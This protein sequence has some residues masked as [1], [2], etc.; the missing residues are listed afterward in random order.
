MSEPSSHSSS[1]PTSSSAPLVPAPPPVRPTWS[2]A[3]E[4]GSV[5]AIT[6]TVFLVTVLGR[7]P[8]RLVARGVAFYYWA[9]SPSTR[10]H[11]ADFLRRVHGRA[12][13]TAEI[14]RQFLRYAQT[15][16]DAFFF[17]AG[18]TAPFRL[19]SHGNEHLT[20]LRDEKRGAILLG[21][22]LGSF[23]AMRARGAERTLPLYAVVYTKH[24]RRI[25]EAFERLDPGRHATLLEMGEGV[26][27]AIKIREI[28]EQGGLVAILADRVPATS[29][30][31]PARSV[32]VDF[33]GA[34]ARFPTGPYLLA[35]MLKC[36]VYL[37]FGLYRDPDGYDL[38]CEPFAERIDLPR[39]R[40][41]EA[42]RAVV[43]QYADRVAHHARSAPDNWFNFYDFWE[44]G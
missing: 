29:D 7:A 41:E 13:T 23:Y 4:R 17:V 3:A 24:A 43:Q 22:H 25:N 2:S 20:R 30:K 19:R 36:P 5:L 6:T 33:L 12:P 18:K 14:Y 28:V 1:T 39:G 40:R 27:F 44:R 11:V 9:A 10:R 35:S 32:E 21:A 26:D 31:G 15:T 42:L 34:K 8:A 37:A 38:F 16:I